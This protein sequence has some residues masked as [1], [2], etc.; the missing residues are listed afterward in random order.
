MNVSPGF[1]RR[2]AELTGGSDA[3]W[4]AGMTTGLVLTVVA[5]FA[6]L[7]LGGGT[8]CAYFGLLIRSA[9]YLS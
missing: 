1:D 9:L 4:L 5:A 3:V 6:P 2:V 7:P 8:M